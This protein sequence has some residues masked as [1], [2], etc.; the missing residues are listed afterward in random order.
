MLTSAIVTAVQSEG[1]SQPD[2][3]A[4]VNEVYLE[5]N[6]EARWRKVSTA[7]TTTVANQKN[8]SVPISIVDIDLIRIG[9]TEYIPVSQ[10]EIW[11]LESGRLTLQGDGGVFAP[12]FESGDQIEIYPAPSTTG[13]SIMALRVIDPDALTVSPDTTPIFPSDLHGPILIDGSKAK[14]IARNDERLQAAS[15]FKGLADIGVEKLKLR[16]AKRIGGMRPRQAKLI[17]RDFV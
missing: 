10:E 17:G 1:V 2:A 7:L 5:A 16:A 11:G 8:Y 6:A 13:D 9:T 14:I 4:V 12:D 3:L 15:Y